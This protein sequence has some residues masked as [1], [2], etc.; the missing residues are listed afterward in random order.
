MIF[1]A[2]DVRN[3]HEVIIN[4]HSEIIGGHT[5]GTDNDE[6]ADSI[7]FKFHLPAD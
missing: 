3:A 6:I 2:N 7:S 4:D 1:S 5:I